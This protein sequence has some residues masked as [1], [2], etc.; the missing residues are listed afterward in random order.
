MS[1]AVVVVVVVVVAAAVVVVGDWRAMWGR[2][3]GRDREK[4]GRARQLVG[5]EGRSEGFEP[6]VSTVSTAVEET[7]TAVAVW[8]LL[9]E[10]LLLK[11]MLTSPLL[12]LVL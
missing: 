1:D 12:E 5:S 4:S 2:R 6:F 7:N 3:E 8:P 11:S 9:L 10:L